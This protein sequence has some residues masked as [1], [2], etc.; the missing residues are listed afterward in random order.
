MNKLL[1]TVDF[2]DAEAPQKFV[3]S[4][5]A[6]GFGVLTNHPIPQETVNSIYAHWLEFFNGDT[7]SQYTFSPDNY[8]GFFAAAV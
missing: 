5:R 2:Q 3:E 1:P 8:D 6:T 7:K 4:L